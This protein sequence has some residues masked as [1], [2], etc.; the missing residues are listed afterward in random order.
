MAI[1]GLVVLALLIAYAVVAAVR[2]ATFSPAEADRTIQVRGT[3]LQPA[4]PDYGQ[5]AIALGDGPVLASRGTQKPAATASTAKLITVL[6]ILQKRP[7]KSGQDG[8]TITIT[9]A[10]V[11]NYERYVS[12]E[13][14]VVP[15][16]VGQQLTERDALEAILLPSANNIADTLAIWAFGSI[17]AYRSA[18]TAWVKQ[19][20]LAHTRIG[21]DASGYAPDTVSTAD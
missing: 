19:H 10:D 1:A 6:V 13:G 3:A 12:V 21:S 5:A 9:A 2:T 17:D 11:R 8:P 7:L 15:V 4:W 20:G 16:S 14:S 18:A